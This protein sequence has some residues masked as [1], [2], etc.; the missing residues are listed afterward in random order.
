MTRSFKLLLTLAALAA[1]G[2]AAL[3]EGP[4]PPSSPIYVITNDDGITHNYVSFFQAG[5]TQGAPTLT[6]AND[7]IT[8]GSG[9]GGGYFGA[10][11]VN[12]LPDASTHCLYASNAG[13]GEI[14]AIDLTTNQ[15]AGNFPASPDDAGDSN[16]VGIAVNA[17]YLY[18]SYTASSTIATFSV[19]PGCQLSFVDDVSAAGLNGGSVAGMALHG[20]I[21]VAAYA[22]GSIESFN[23]ANGLPQS[24]GDAQNSTA[25]LRSGIH[26]PESVDI[27]AD[28]H[29][30]LFG[31]SSIATVVEVSDVSA[32][33]LSP[34]VEY[35]V[36]GVSHAVGVGVNSGAPAK[37]MPGHWRV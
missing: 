18:A 28:G 24:N 8:R 30:A 10:Q 25:F 6:F 19:L 36:S 22:D 1:S 5:G 35:T 2:A 13:S 21:L 11:R 34:T 3:A 29:F 4:H 14:S 32:G 7:V 33:H 37:W 15:L 23:I 12:L 16:G 27:S 17:N 9:I 26:F 31:D 20:D